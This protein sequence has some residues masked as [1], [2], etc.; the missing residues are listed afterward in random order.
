MIIHLLFILHKPSHPTAQRPSQVPLQVF[1][2]VDTQVSR[3][4]VSSSFIHA[5]SNGVKEDKE[6]IGSRPHPVFFMNSL[7]V[8]GS[9]FDSAYTFLEDVLRLAHPPT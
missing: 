9:I 5:V 4:S 3:Q 6:R 7:R 1:E 2:H 8:I